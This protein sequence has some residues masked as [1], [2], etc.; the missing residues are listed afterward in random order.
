[1]TTT[2]SEPEL[3]RNV[4]QG[5]HDAMLRRRQIPVWVVSRSADGFR[6]FLHGSQGP[7]NVSAYAATLESLRS[8]MPDGL[9][10]FPRSSAD[11]PQIVETWL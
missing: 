2:L 5:A 8:L 1:M 10:V 11:A 3:R 7:I 9:D 4:L 6:V